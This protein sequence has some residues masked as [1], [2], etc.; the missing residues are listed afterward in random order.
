MRGPDLIS[1]AICSQS[2][3]RLELEPCRRERRK[4]EVR[5]R[6]LDAARALF[7]TRSFA[8]T[9][10][11]EICEQAD[12]AEKTFFNHFPSKQDLLSELAAE[13]L[14]AILESIERARKQGRSTPERIRLFFDAVADS[15]ADGGPPQRELMTE[16]VHVVH[17]LPASS[18]PRDPARRLHEAMGALVADGLEAG[19]VTRRHEPETLTE[20][21]LGA[22][23]VLAFNFVHLDSFPVRKQAVAVARFLADAFA[24]R[25]DEIVRGEAGVFRRREPADDRILE[26]DDGPA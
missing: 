19:D 14:D 11:V 3:G 5:T 2:A 8:Q 6:I 12:V 23:Y 9:R 21:L 22:Y 13:G 16:L 7:R 18:D 10:V 15:L 17:V 1:P 4:L 26:A 20:M 25:S 24:P